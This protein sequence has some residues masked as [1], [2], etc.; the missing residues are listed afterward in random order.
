MR[1]R[2][3]WCG[4]GWK[5][6]CCLAL[7][8]GFGGTAFAY[9]DR[10]ALVIGNDAYP[11]EPLKNAANDA[12]AMQKA[13][14]DVGFKVVF[15]PNANFTNMRSAAVEFSKLLNE[16]NGATAALFYFAGHG[17]QYRDKNFLVPIDAMLASEAEITF[18]ALELGQILEIMEDAKVR[19][20]FVVLD[21]CRNNPFRNIF[22]SSGLAKVSRVPPGTTIAYAAAAGA[23]ALDGDEQNG[24]YTKH[25]LREI[26]NPALQARLMFDNVASAVATESNSKQLPEIQSTALPTGR[27]F[28]FAERG[29]AVAGSSQTNAPT[30]LTAETSALIDRDFWNDVKDSKKVEDFQAYLQQFPNGIYASRAKSRIDNLRQEKSGT[31]LAIP[32]SSAPKPLPP[33]Q[34][35]VALASPVGSPSASQEAKAI[36]SPALASEAAR[37]VPAALGVAKPEVSQILVKPV[38]PALASAPSSPAATTNESRGIEA[39][40]VTPAPSTAI[41]APALVASNPAA[42]KMPVPTPPPV[43]IASVSPEQRTSLP[44]VPIGPK[45][46]TGAIDFADGAR[47]VGEYKEN[48]DKLQIMH[49]QGEFTSKAFRYKGEFVDNRKQGRGLHVWANGDKYEGDFV[50]EEPTGKGV[51]EFATGEKYQGEVSK[52]K[53]NGRGVLT[54]KSGD[55]FTGG[56]VNG[57][58]EGKGV[59]AFANGDRYEGGMKSGQISGEGVYTSKNGDRREATFVNGVAEGKGAYHFA[60]G[61][62]YD[63]EFKAGALTGTGVYHYA[64]GLRTEGSYVNGALMGQGKFIFNDGS[65]FEGIFEAGGQRAKGVSTSKDGLK[66]PAEIV[67]GRVIALND[68]R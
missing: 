66:R 13:L 12:R 65:W 11:T 26:R 30:A 61:D 25:L 56:F 40:P 59:Y 36:S 28:F 54:S 18:N 38:A 32:A 3:K 34:E 50:D 53:F 55:Q 42:T 31:A 45:I 60:N 27:P 22:Q 48:K 7:A 57:L 10:I 21:A 52:G 15:R 19:H 49:G 44:P 41:Q 14:L 33:A 62:R 35:Q 9:D 6:L 16:A 24:L 4:I 58:Q 8:W 68:G 64:N 23:V 43:Q 37:V 1:T 5:M 20:K 46:I 47:Y 17:I 63:G 39:R 2:M 51:W 29:T 67:D